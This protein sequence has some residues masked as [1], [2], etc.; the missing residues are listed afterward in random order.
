MNPTD[1]DDYRLMELAISLYYEGYSRE[2]LIKK[3]MEKVNDPR[4]A[5]RFYNAVEKCVRVNRDLENKRK[6]ELNRE[7]LKKSIDEQKAWEKKKISERNR[8]D[9][10]DRH[11]DVFD[12][13]A[14][15]DKAKELV[16]QKQTDFIVRNFDKLSPAYQ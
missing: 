1:Y 15:A 12:L 7:T 10:G 4:K 11:V 8:D 16:S 3:L 14:K 2:M 5:V 9:D 6:A 13:V